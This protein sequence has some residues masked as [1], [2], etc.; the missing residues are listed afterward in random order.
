MSRFLDIARRRPMLIGGSV[1]AVALLIWLMMRGG[2]DNAPAPQAAG[3][4]IDQAIIASNTALQM[5][6]IEANTQS[7][8]IS[9]SLTSALDQNKVVAKGLE[10]EN[11]AYKYGADTAL[12]MQNSAQAGN[13]RLAALAASMALNQRANDTFLT[14][15]TGGYT[16]DQQRWFG[17]S[18]WS[19]PSAL[20][21][22]VELGYSVPTGYNAQKLIAYMTGGGQPNDYAI[23]LSTGREDI[24]NKDTWSAEDAAYLAQYGGYRKNINYG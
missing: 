21:Q 18:S 5:S 19:E 10:L 4:G 23:G 6:Q 16:S 24:K 2:G 12:A 14:L 1:I 11:A 7:A 8:A 9:A 20:E 13:E 3:S 22:A 17:N 15:V